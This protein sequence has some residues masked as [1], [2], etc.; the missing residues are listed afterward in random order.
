MGVQFIGR[1]EHVAAAHVESVRIY[2]PFFMQHVQRVPE[3]PGTPSVLSDIPVGHI[4][5]TD[6]FARRG[7]S[8][9]VCVEDGLLEYV[10]PGVCRRPNGST[11]SKV[12]WEDL[13]RS[14]HNTMGLDVHVGGFTAL[15][16]QGFDHPIRFHGLQEAWM[17]S[18]LFPDWLQ[19]VPVDVRLM[20]R[21]KSLFEDPRYGISDS[22]DLWCNDRCVPGVPMSIPERAFLEAIDDMETAYYVIDEMIDFAWDLR[23]DV[24]DKLMQHCR[25]SYVRRVFCVFADRHQLPW[26]DEMDV[27]RINLSAGSRAGL[28]GGT[29]HPRFNVRVPEEFALPYEPWY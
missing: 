16:C 20:L 28:P 21:D 25:K 10:A 22:G 15:S 24:L 12:C 2:S 13:V 19:T 11:R 26:W 1:L 23:A 18:E 8:M 7:E 27:D 29:L 5:D 4:V 6:W 14:L 17:Y 3:R 9:R